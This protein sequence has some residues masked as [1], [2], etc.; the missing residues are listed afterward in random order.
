MPAAS[1]TRS[2]ALVQQRP[3]LPA[4]VMFSDEERA[5]IKQQLAPDTNDAEFKMFLYF[6]AAKGVNPLLGQVHCVVYNKNNPKKRRM[7]LI[8]SVHTLL[9]RAHETGLFA[10]MDEPEIIY[11]AGPSAK[12]ND[13]LNPRNIEACKVTGY[14]WG[15]RG[16]KGSFTVRVRWDEFRK[17]EPEWSNGQI[18][19]ERLGG[20]W[21]EMPEH[22]L[23]KCTTAHLLRTML[24]E[25]LAG[26]YVNEEVDPRKAEAYSIQQQAPAIEEPRQPAP[27]S[28]AAVNGNS[29]ASASTSEDEVPL[30]GD[31]VEDPD[32]NTGYA[33]IPYRVASAKQRAWFFSFLEKRWKLDNA[34]LLKLYGARERLPLEVESQLMGQLLQ[35][36][37]VRLEPSDDVGGGGDEDAIEVKYSTRDDATE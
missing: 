24:P 23:E 25:Q 26:M 2:R 27:E 1:P 3:Q 4:N 11:K 28:P 13:P 22:M 9:L 32:W 15:P 35:D 29:H 18:V 36:I 19:G 14:K 7:V 17:V 5:L 8:T 10:G 33:A 37:H 21:G 20:Q 16:L 31:L 12:Q 6:S 34:G 30:G